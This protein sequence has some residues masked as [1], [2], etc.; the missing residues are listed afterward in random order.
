LKPDLSRHRGGSRS[1]IRSVEMG[2]LET[3]RS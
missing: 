1:T 2:G 3:G